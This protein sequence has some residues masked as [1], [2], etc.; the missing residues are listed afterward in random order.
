MNGHRTQIFL[1]TAKNRLLA[2]EGPKEYM[3][4]VYK[5][6][7][8]VQRS[9]PSFPYDVKREV[10]ISGRQAVERAPIPNRKAV[11]NRTSHGLHQYEW[12]HVS[13]L[14]ILA[15]PKLLRTY[16]GLPL[17]FALSMRLIRKVF[18]G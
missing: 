5:I 16:A 6:P 15:P 14:S 4:Y 10:R 9:P 1:K 8:R 17:T 3:C 18:M 2:A 12:H 13:S 11:E 7:N